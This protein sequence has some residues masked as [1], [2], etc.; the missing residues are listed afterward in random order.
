M[1]R[2]KIMQDRGMEGNGE[3]KRRKK[4]VRGRERGKREKKR[5][6][7]LIPSPLSLPSP[8]R[9]EKNLPRSC[10][11]PG[12]TRPGHPR[13][14]LVTPPQRWP[15]PHPHGPSGRLP[16]PRT[17]REFQTSP[18]QAPPPAGIPALSPARG[19]PAPSE[20]S[21]PLQRTRGGRHHL[22]TPPRGS[23]DSRLQFPK[24]LC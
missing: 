14:V 8:S 5:S 10:C 11:S 4:V 18:H 23:G 21:H 9:G 22:P 24:L 16:R 1:V 3:K 13:D 15:Q 17:D 19:I 2:E 7:V 20:D 6:L 12:R